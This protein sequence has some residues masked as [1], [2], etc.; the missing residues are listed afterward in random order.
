LNILLSG[1]ED[2]LNLGVDVESVRKMVLVLAS[3]I[4]ATCVAFCGVIGFVGLIVPHMMRLIVGPDH[5]I[6]LPSS[7][8]AG[9]IF[10]IWTDTLAREIIAPTELPV[11]IITAILG[12]PF[13]LFLLRSRKKQMGFWK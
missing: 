13:F 5:R 11:G 12:V 9:A 3:L 2:A 4:T 8:L 10:L 7:F 6:L 1:E